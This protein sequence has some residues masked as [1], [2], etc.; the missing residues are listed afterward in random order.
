MISLPS[1]LLLAVGAVGVVA[2]AISV[3]LGL[4]DP[5]RFFRDYLVAYTFWL[6]LALGCLGVALVQFLTGGVW[7]LLTRRIFEA[8]AATLPVLAVLFVPVLLG[9]PSLYVWTHT[10]AVAVDPNLAH[11]AI[12]LNVP[13]FVGRAIVYFAAWIGIA[14][15]LTRWSRLQD[16]TTDPYILRRLQRLSI[17]GLLV[18]ALTVSFAAIDW[19]MSLEPDWVSTLYPGLMCMSDLL[20]ALAFAVLLIA[21]PGRRGPLAAVLTPGRLNDLGSLLLAF[22]MLWAYLMYFQY[23]LI[24]AGNLPSEISWYVRRAEGGWEPLAWFVAGVGFLAPFWLLLFR[25]LKRSGR[26]LGAIAGLLVV[27]Q[28]VA[29]YWLVEPAF[30]PDGPVFDLLQPLLGI[31]LGAVWLSVFAWRLRTAPLLPPNDPRLLPAMEAAR[32]TA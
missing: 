14:L 28:V 29:E 25:P 10:E 19:W 24:W 1:R 9:L 7:G 6:G 2:L 13:F 5:A 32:A 20:L 15:L 22:L 27:M 26:W 3:G 4:A 11:K 31:A 18:L 16:R 21:G 23:M 12:Y 30:A 17:V 8:G